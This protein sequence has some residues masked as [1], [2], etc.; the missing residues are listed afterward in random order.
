MQASAHRLLHLGV[1]F[2][3]RRSTL[4]DA[5]KRRDPTFFEELYHDLYKSHYGHLPDS[6]KGKKIA[7]RLFIVDSSIIKLFSTILKMS[8]SYCCKGRKK[9]GIKAH[10]VVKSKDD[11]PGFV[12]L[13]EGT[14][15]DGTFLPL[16][17]LPAGSIV[18]MDRGYRNF[19][20]FI[21]WN[22]NKITW[23]TRLHRRTF[24]ENIEDISVSETQKLKG[25][26]SDTVI[27]M[28]SR[29]LTHANPIQKVRRIVFYDQQNDRD[30]EFIT[31]NMQLA[32]ATIADIYKKRWQIELFFKRIKQNFQLHTFLGDNENAIRIQVW[33]ALIADLLLKVIKDKVDKKRKW[34][35][36]NLASFVRLHLGTYIDIRKF[37]CD[38]DK[39]LLNYKAPPTD[40]FTLFPTQTRGA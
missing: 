38:P 5:N 33:C 26:K 3:P 35:M 19:K 4:S 12:R 28:G 39:S 11:V 10:M 29:H 36:S 17:T 32:P 24:Y 1:R 9:G 31:N 18:V 16:L 25:V 15:G 7:D 8:S 21:D 34:S 30:F 22:N 27:A 13:T 20:Q 40:Q 37:L 14:Q 23:V 6:L 2:S